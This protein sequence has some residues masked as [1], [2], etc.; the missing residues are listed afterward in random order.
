VAR[1]AVERTEKRPYCENVSDNTFSVESSA[2][3]LHV[4]FGWDG[5]VALSVPRSN[6][7]SHAA[8]RIVESPSE[9]EEILRGFGLPEPEAAGV[10]AA[11]WKRRPPDAPEEQSAAGPSYDSGLFLLIAL[12]ALG[13]GVV[14]LASVTGAL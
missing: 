1:A 10:S 7:A 13:A 2:G 14:L 9:L 8:R 3:R 4:E 11:L 6:G 12:I 5:W